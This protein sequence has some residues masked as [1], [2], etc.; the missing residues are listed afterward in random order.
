M[1]RGA[2]A[3]S[4]TS[5][6]ITAIYAIGCVVTIIILSA[7][8]RTVVA[9]C[10]VMSVSVGASVIPRATSV[11]VP[12]VTSTIGYV[13]RGTS[14]VQ[15][16]T[17]RIARIDAEVPVACIEIY[18]TIEVMGCQICLVLPLKEDV[19][20]VEVSACPICAVKISLCLNTQQVVEVDFESCFVLV[21]CEIKLISHLVGKEQRLFACLFVTH[22]VSAC[23]Y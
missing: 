12:R 3:A 9:F 19:A 18:R 14:E 4:T 6:A 16:G 2:C 11:T 21:V 13:E 1:L 23:H 5:A 10:V 22:C 17:M 8:T 15:E 20:E 7:H